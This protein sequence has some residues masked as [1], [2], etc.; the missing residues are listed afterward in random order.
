MCSGGLRWVLLFCTDFR[1]VLDSDGL[2]VRGFGGAVPTIHWGM[3]AADGLAEV[4]KVLTEVWWESGS[5]N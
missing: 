5:A 2:A 3:A 4:G 1:G